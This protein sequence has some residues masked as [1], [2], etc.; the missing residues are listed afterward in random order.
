VRI[1]VSDASVLFD[2]ADAD[3]LLYC[4]R[5]PYEFQIAD[6]MFEQELLSFEPVARE[7]LVEAGLVVARFEGGEVL[8]AI[9]LRARYRALS[10]PDAFALLLARRES[11]IL[12]TGDRRLRNAATTEGVERHGHLW[13]IEQ[14]SEHKVV[15]DLRLV[16]VLLAWKEDP[17]VRLPDNENESLRDRLVP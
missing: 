7:A 8:E 3:L 11:A 12:L 17:R 4:F 6:V 9:E 13:M 1:I 14:L 15:A 2:F 10:T 5:L 16:D